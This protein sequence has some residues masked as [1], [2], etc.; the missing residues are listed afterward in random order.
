MKYVI[1]IDEGTTSTRA[2]LYDL[3][4]KRITK[5]V[6]TPIKQYYPKP[7]FVEEDANEI[8]AHT[9]SSLVEIIESVS[10]QSAIAGIGVTNQRE[11][12]VCWDKSSGKPLYNAIIWQCRRTAEYMRELGISCGET[13]RKKTGLVMDA[14]FSASKMKWLVDNVPEIGEKVKKGEVCFGTID[15]YIIYK[16]TGGR[17][18]VTDVTNASRTMLFNINTL[19]YDDELLKIFGIP[20]EAL[21]KIVSCDE[22]VGYYRYNGKNIPIC[23]IAGD[24]QAALVGQ[25]CLSEGTGK[26]TYGTG[27]F[28]LYNVADRSIISQ[29]GLI[30][31]VGYKIG[32]KTTF[33][34]EGSVFNAGSAVQWLRDEMG[35]FPRSKD[36]EA[37]ATS[38]PDNGGVYAV[39]AFTGLGAPYWNSEAR[40]II[41]GITRGTTRAHITRAVLESMAYSA[42]DLALVMQ[43]ESGIALSELRCDGGASFNDFLMQFQANVLGARVDRPVEKESTA[44]GA[45]YLCALGLG[46]ISEKD[47]SAL[48]KTERIFSPEKDEKYERFYSEWKKAVLKAVSD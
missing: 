4:K 26:V 15:S 45:A 19:D 47:I 5:Q 2:V 35:F 27:L 13:I 20:R 22:L 39:P 12:V 24:Q 36:S 14:Y 3:E 17:S 43:E 30:T 41:C 40:G 10:D 11:T 37:L 21:P 29:N 38:V 1:A 18:F 32:G 23:G 6:N 9:L 34:F 46:L 16:L 48:R 33:A 7:S 8:Y 44:L 31:T 28:M 25:G 42:K